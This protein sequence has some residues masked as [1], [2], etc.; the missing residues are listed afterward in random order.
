MRVRVR[1]GCMVWVAGIQAKL[2]IAFS[3]IDFTRGQCHHRLFC[4]IFC[5]V[6]ISIVKMLVV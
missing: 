5:L 2:T 3:A 1:D 4:G 6:F